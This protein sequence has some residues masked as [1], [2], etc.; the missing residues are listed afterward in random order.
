MRPL[1]NHLRKVN[2]VGND[3]SIVNGKTIQD[4]VKCSAICVQNKAI[5]RDTKTM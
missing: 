4:R 2:A 5:E 1:S 3:M